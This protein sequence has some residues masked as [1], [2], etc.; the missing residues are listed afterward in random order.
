M[1]GVVQPYVLSF[2][3]SAAVAKLTMLYPLPPLADIMGLFR[4][5]QLL[6]QR[7]RLVAIVAVAG[8]ILNT[9]LV[10]RAQHKSANRVYEHMTQTNVFIS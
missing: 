4:T 1:T 2:L 8:N 7:L 10:V 6:S 9:A 5:V 3:A